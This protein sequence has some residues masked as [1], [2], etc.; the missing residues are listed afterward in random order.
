MSPRVLSILG[1]LLWLL[2]ALL[3]TEKISALAQNADDKP[4]DQ[5]STERNSA[6]EAQTVAEFAE[7]RRLLD[8]PAGNPECVWLGRLIG[9]H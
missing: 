6:K 5:Q 8:G 1:G 2:A 4:P 3:G 9:L 7:A